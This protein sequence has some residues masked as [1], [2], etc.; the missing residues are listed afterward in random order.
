MSG[1]GRAD[2]Q[3][4]NE[5]LRASEERLRLMI[6]GVKDHAIYMLDTEGRVISWN[7]G[8]ARPASTATPPRR[9]WGNPT[10]V[11]SPPKMR[12]RDAPCLNSMRRRQREVALPKHGGFAKTAP[13]FGPT[14]RRPPCGSTAVD[15]ED[16]GRSSVILRSGSKSKTNCGKSRISCNSGIGQYGRCHKA[17]SSPIPINPT[18]RSF[19]LVPAS[20]DSPGIR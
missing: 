10:V 9:L 15:C 20:N 7:E 19:T 16:M 1:S 17:S 5:R 4:L 6:E 2:L 12:Q 14:R 13:D 11:S 8:A 18:I 3:R